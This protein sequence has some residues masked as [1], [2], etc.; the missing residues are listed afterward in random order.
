MTRY[1]FRAPRCKWFRRERYPGEARHTGVLML[2]WS[3]ATVIVVIAVV[4]VAVAV[5]VAVVVVVVVVG[6]I[7]GIFTHRG[8]QLDHILS[9]SLYSRIRKVNQH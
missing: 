1:T 8:G 7:G 6:G 3:K 4:V 5:A 2:S 9:L